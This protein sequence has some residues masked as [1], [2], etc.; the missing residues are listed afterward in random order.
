[1][2][3]I[4]GEMMRCRIYYVDTD[5]LLNFLNGF[6]LQRMAEDDS[7]I[8]HVP[9]HD[10]LPEDAVIR[11]VCYDFIRDSMVV[12]I[13]SKTFDEVNNGNIPPGTVQE[14]SKRSGCVILKKGLGRIEV[15][16][17]SFPKVG[18]KTKLL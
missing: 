14:I 13:E 3:Q 11:R 8:F 16:D 10:S 12:V 18:R 4:T 2:D 17:D 15:Q 1:M 9:I 5:M 7:Y 6:R